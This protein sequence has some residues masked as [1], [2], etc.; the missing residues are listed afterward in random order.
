V[1]WV[2]DSFGS[3]YDCGTSYTDLTYPINN[4]NAN[5]AAEDWVFTTSMLTW[6]ATSIKMNIEIP[7]G[8]EKYVC[9]K[10]ESVS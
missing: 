9:L 3:Q 7:A 8:W 10:C 1:D 5:A 2:R 4:N 6:D